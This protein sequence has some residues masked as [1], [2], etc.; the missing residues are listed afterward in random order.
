MSKSIQ[1]KTGATRQ[2]TALNGC[3]ENTH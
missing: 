3:P 2:E 1:I